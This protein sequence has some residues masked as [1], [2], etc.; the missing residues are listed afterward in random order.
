MK[1]NYAIRNLSVGS[2]VH[3]DTTKCEPDWL[4]LVLA[5]DPDQVARPKR[6]EQY[7]YFTGLPFGDD[8][9]E[10]VYVN[11]ALDVLPEECHPFFLEECARVLKLQG[12]DPDTLQNELL[13]SV[14]KRQASLAALGQTT[15][16]SGSSLESGPKVAL[17]STTDFGGAAI[18]G[19][20]LHQGL[21]SLNYPSMAY[22]QYKRKHDPYVYV[23]PPGR[24]DSMIPDKMGGYL[25]QSRLGIMQALAQTLAAYPHRPA[26]SESFT[27]SEAGTLDLGQVPLLD[28]FDILHFHWVAGF[29]DVEYNLPFL[30]GKKIVWT[31]HD[32]NP[33]TGGCHYNSGCRA[34]EQ[35]CGGCPQ[36]GSQVLTDFSR[37]TWKRR[38]RA[39]KNLDI[40][41][42]CPSFWLAKEAEASSLFGDFPVHV[43]P[44]GL[45]LETFRPMNR[46]ATR[47]ALEFKEDD[48]VL[49]F[50]ADSVVNRR[51]GI[52]YLIAAL[53]HLEKDPAHKKIVLVLLGQGGEA[54][55]GLQYRVKNLGSL[56][57]PRHVALAYNAADA[58]VLPTLEDN[59][60]NVALEALAC[61]T[62]VL[63]SKVGGL[64][65]IVEHGKQGY[66]FPPE[67]PVS[68][69]EAILWLLR[70]K[71]ENPTL[72]TKCR[73]KAL[74]AYP[75]DIQAQHY[76][77]LYKQLVPGQKA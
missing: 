36:L 26:G 59:L 44:Y 10:R 5:K 46:Q 69:V 25:L 43:I 28:T 64:P 75:L 38:Q 70:Q 60:P 47:Q 8:S 35:K 68:I 54:V 39:Y 6:L 65:D 41:V 19:L 52:A 12:L 20:R 7:L 27:G 62:P 24:H 49:L 56:D 58:L 17:F 42:V 61:G 30:Q 72:G 37:I 4:N 21:R 14:E 23:L 13:P 57:D 16:A 67:D 2:S 74:E 34:F 71:A 66:L 45:P 18:A 53:R 77:E 11:C 55:H 48:C 22:V 3:E 29:M 31:L 50:N 40:T 32:M 15:A 73:A 9:F 76:I 33:F 63:A 1:K 51:K